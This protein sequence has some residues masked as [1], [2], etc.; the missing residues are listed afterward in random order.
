MIQLAGSGIPNFSQSGAVFFRFDRS[1]R[2]IEPLLD[3]M[4]TTRT[5]RPTS[6]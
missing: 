6:W 2:G 4:A 1:F 5:R 3:P